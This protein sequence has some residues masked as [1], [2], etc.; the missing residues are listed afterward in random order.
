VSN[1]AVENSE[2]Y[3]HITSIE[4]K[5]CGRCIEACPRHVLQL[6]AEL[7]ARG[8]RF[9]RYRGDGCSGCANCFYVCPE[10]HTFEIRR[11]KHR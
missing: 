5:G 3:P 9:V 2:P 7:N 4:C 10:P 11:P 1:P 6:G 8:Y